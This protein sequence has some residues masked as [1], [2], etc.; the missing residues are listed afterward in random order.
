MPTADGRNGKLRPS[1]IAFFGFP[2]HLLARA[3]E[4]AAVNRQ[5]LV[6][7]P[8]GVLTGKPGRRQSFPCK[9]FRPAEKIDFLRNANLSPS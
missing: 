7:T 5:E 4:L 6:T 3:Q 1:V 2:A 9:R 8:G